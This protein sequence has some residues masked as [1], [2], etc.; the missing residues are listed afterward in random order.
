MGIIECARTQKERVAFLAGLLEIC[1]DGRN[2]GFFCL[3]VQLLPL[4]ELQ[5]VF[6][7]LSENLAIISEIKARAAFLR[8]AFSQLASQKGLTLKLR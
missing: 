6:G 5:G 7:R 4:D 1:N 3:A 8:Q 2:K